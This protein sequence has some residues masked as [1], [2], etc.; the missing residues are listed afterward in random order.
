MVSY[1]FWEIK[2]EDIMKAI[3]FTRFEATVNGGGG[4]RR[5]SQI[6]DILSQQFEYKVETTRQKLQSWR[7]DKMWDGKKYQW[8]KDKY[9]ILNFW[10]EK[11]Y[12]Y[13]E[14]NFHYATEW[15]EIYRDTI[16]N[17][18]LILIDD[19]IYFA[20]LVDYMSKYTH[21]PI[22]AF[23]H[24]IESLSVAQVYK[25]K[26][27]ELLA[28][29][30]ALLKKCDLCITISR[31]ETFLL[32]NFGMHTLYFPY[33]PPQSIEGRMKKVRKARE[34]TLKKN[35]LFIGTVYNVPTGEGLISLIEA[36]DKYQLYK[37]GHH[38]YIAGFG[39]ENYIKYSK[40]IEGIEF[41][42]SIDD[43]QL[44]LLLSEIAALIIYQKTGSGALTKI[45]EMLIAGV[46]I[47]ANTHAIRSYYNLPG[48][49]EFKSFADIEV[50]LNESPLKCIDISM[51]E[52]PNTEYLINTIKVLLEKKNFKEREKKD[53]F[54]TE[55]QSVMDE[56]N[57]QLKEK[58]KH[59]EKIKKQIKQKEEQTVYLTGL[60]EKVYDVC[61]D[62][63][64]LSLFHSKRKKGISGGNL[65]INR[66]RK[67]KI[68]HI[69]NPVKVTEKS[70]L[71]IAQPVTFETMRRAKTA[72]KEEND[73]SIELYFTCYEEDLLVAPD[74]FTNAGLLEKSVLDYGTFS[75]KRKLPI[76]KDILDR[77]YEA[78]DADYFIYTNVDI[79][80][81]P[82][83]YTEVKKIIESGYDG[84]VINRRT[85][86]DTFDSVNDIEKMYA[87]KGEKHPGYDCFVFKREA[88]PKYELGTAC[89][90]ANWIGRVIIS[91]VIAHADHFK[92]FEDEHLTF[93]IGDDRS[94]K[95]SEYNDY[96]KHNEKIV[97]S[98]L[99]KLMDDIS[100]HT[101]PLLK[102]F[103][104]YHT[105]KDIDIL[106]E[107]KI[108]EYHTVTH[109]NLPASIEYIYGNTYK[110][111]SKWKVPV[112]LR[113]DPIFVI[114]YPRS[115]TTFLQSLLTTQNNIVSLPETHFFN[116]VKS[117][118]KLT[119][120]R[121]SSSDINSIT[122]AIRQRVQFSTNAE[123]H[124]KTLANQNMLSAK[125][126]F[127]ILV[128]DNLLKQIPDINTL[129]NSIWLEKTPDNTLH[130]EV[131]QKYYPDARFIYIMRNPE[132]AIISRRENFKNEKNASVER[133]AKA[134]V[135]S[136]TAMETFQKNHPHKIKVISLENL[137]EDKNSVMKEI[138]SFLKVEFEQDKLVNYKKM[139][140]QIVL[141]WEK[142]VQTFNISQKTASNS[143]QLSDIDML[144]VLKLSKNKLLKYGYMNTRYQDLLKYNTAT[145]KE[146]PSNIVDA[147]EKLCSYSILR[148]PIKK[149]RAYKKLLA[150]YHQGKSK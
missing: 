41:I 83:F 127:E 102:E 88:Y 104:A 142:D 69:I 59:I 103:Y 82:E 12:D 27:S 79:A 115:G 36:W 110:P 46:P 44:D 75:K 136:I 33:Y 91:N 147:F 123:K 90:G 89:I 63:H 10:Q 20:P 144:K 108:I 45:A 101:K 50:I 54:I 29:E 42:G 39:T 149:Y 52:K 81:M 119:N 145:F 73:L 15:V 13:V 112:I 19:P 72:A 53:T 35:I 28:Y 84:F 60:K 3:F 148:N 11:Y 32:E 5:F 141:P 26:V 55:H 150:T 64:S 4:V 139:A 49:Y 143:K 34:N 22:V 92:V 133:L 8:L 67:M 131:I 99:E 77:L 135:K 37:T 121:I 21:I 14:N 126:L 97:I 16:E 128:V 57:R 80:L 68:A 78:S 76:I 94:W 48:I 106:T 129:K 9:P 134:W 95:I 86:S 140:Y 120:D 30:L 62:A 87:D 113:Q 125:M 124:I 100:M 66:G 117:K 38:L 130:L 17:F 31:E 43:K 2:E 132:Q 116:W 58:Q 111:S 122:N 109:Q 24:N 85:I 93:H 98:L 61:L 118:L 1:F 74:G 6:N 23:L 40:D 18:D 56:H 25:D 105:K 107:Q 146:T 47:L 114:G 96:D 51:F 7:I 71:F 137:T 70:D 65:K 138:C